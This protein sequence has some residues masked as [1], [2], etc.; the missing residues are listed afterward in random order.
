MIINRCMTKV[1]IMRLGLILV[2]IYRRIRIM[3]RIF[4]LHR[5]VYMRTFY[6][7]VVDMFRYQIVVFFGII[8]GQDEL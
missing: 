5:I 8:Y 3:V 4:I 7:P 6:L 1:R 2:Y